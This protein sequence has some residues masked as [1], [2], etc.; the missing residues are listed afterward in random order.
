MELARD[1]D[2]AFHR[3]G[4]GIAEEHE[5]RE[6]RSA[7]PLGQALAVRNPVQIGDVP[8]LLGLRAQCVD[9]MR[10]RVAEHIDR[11][12][13]AEIEIA[14]AVRRNEPRA[15]ASLE[16]EVDARISRQQVRRHGRLVCSVGV[17]MKCA[18]SPGGT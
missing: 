8:E 1:L 9:E 7:K 13:A 2:R 3:L 4:A 17:E 16:G 15:L 10:M 6:R 14:L 11:D 5:V 18:A 12:A